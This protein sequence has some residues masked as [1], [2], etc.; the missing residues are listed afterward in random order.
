MDSEFIMNM[1]V[2]KSTIKKIVETDLKSKLQ[3]NDLQ[4]I[5]VDQQEILQ[6]S[7]DTMKFLIKE[8]NKNIAFLLCCYSEFGD[9][10]LRNLKKITKIKKKL[11]KKVSS[12]LLEPIMSG[13]VEGVCF[14]VWPYCDALSDHFL[15]HRLQS[16]NVRSRS[17]SWLRKVNKKSRRKLKRS[18]VDKHFINL[19]KRFGARNDLDTNVKEA[20]NMQ[21]Q[22][23]ENGSW[24]P[25]F[26]LAHN[27]LWIGNVL[28]NENNKYNGLTIIDWASARRKKGFAIYDL[29]RLSMSLNLSKRA[30]NKE[31]EAHCKILHCDVRNSMGYLL[32]SLAFLAENLDQFPEERFLSLVNSC[33]EYI[34]SRL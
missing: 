24:H 15:I 1:I 21:V 26:V 13:E 9:I 10:P 12:V 4:F 2:S 29:V 31:L 6:N 32:A 34:D 22:S 23:L 3:V 20:I 28:M 16:M 7:D 11:S 17:L 14:V 8:G 27:D 30:F 5:G 25:Y 18:E 33:F 19:L